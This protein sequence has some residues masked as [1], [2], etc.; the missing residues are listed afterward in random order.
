MMSEELILVIRE[1]AGLKVKGNHVSFNVHSVVKVP[2]LHSDTFLCPLGYIQMCVVYHQ[3]W[4]MINSGSMLNL[5][6]T[7]LV[8]DMVW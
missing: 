2:H 8:R 3:V 1:N 7:N 5:L 4:K 6:P